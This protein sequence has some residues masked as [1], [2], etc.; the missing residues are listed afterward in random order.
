MAVF[1]GLT[2]YVRSIDEH[3]IILKGLVSGVWGAP[4]PALTIWRIEN[5]AQF[6][7]L[8]ERL[9]EGRPTR[10]INPDHSVGK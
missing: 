2:R 6:S 1:R 10:T 4:R 9:C 7:S 3:Y 8:L 5:L